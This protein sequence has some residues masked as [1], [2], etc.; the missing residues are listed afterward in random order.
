M[1]T[2][3]EKETNI[4]VCYL[5]DSK[6]VDITDTNTIISEGGTPKLII[7]DL[8]SSNAILRTGVDAVSNYWAWKYKHDGSSWSAN[9]DFKGANSL[10]SGINDSINQIPVGNTNPLL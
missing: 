9:A 6:D 4:S 7:P 2:I 8:N 1:K 3:V 10:T 5:A